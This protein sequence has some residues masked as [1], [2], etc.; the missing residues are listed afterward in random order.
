MLADRYDR[1]RIVIAGL[2]ILSAASYAVA[3]PTEQAI[4]AD[5]AGLGLGRAMGIYESATL[6]GATIGAVTA[7][8]LYQTGN[9]WQTAS[10]A[11]AAL[12]LLTAA[13]VR[14]ALRATNTPNHPAPAPPT[15]T[16]S[17]PPAQALTGDPAASTEALPKSQ[18]STEAP[19][20]A[21]T[22]AP[23]QAETEAA[24]LSPAE[25]TRKD[26]RR[27]ASHAGI[28]TLAQLALILIGH[29]WLLDT[30]QHGPPAG[31]RWWNWLGGNN[32]R[33]TNALTNIGRIWLIIFTIDLLWT[34]TTAL[35]RHRRPNP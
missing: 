10:L 28:F 17:K 16:A 22:D 33:S 1:G 4:V 34:L 15:P 26:L 2:W 5:A 11:A 6:L 12:L 35:L 14:P 30:I 7:G 29:S 23:A 31:G 3:I 32:T 19:V 25:K 24:E 21:A 27:L 8:F 9:G 18:P 20:Q 13:F